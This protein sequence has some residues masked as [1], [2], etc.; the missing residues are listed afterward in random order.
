[1]NFLRNPAWIGSLTS[2]V[3]EGPG[4]W[5]LFNTFDISNGGANGST[6]STGNAN[7]AATTDYALQPRVWVDAAGRSGKSIRFPRNSE[8]AGGNHSHYRAYL[9]ADNTYLGL[10]NMQ[11]EGRVTSSILIPPQANYRGNV[12]TDP[13]VWWFGGVVASTGR[14][15]YFGFEL[16]ATTLGLYNEAGNTFNVAATTTLALGVQPTGWLDVDFRY[17]LH[18]STGYLWLKLGSYTPLYLQGLNTST[19]NPKTLYAMGCGSLNGAIEDLTY[20]GSVTNVRYWS[21]I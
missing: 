5:A 6:Y 12:F 16:A 2:T 7:V 1:M 17:R 18:A 9:Q 15:C 20:F 19:A 3:T 14:S 11:T 4:N 10:G 21:P 13:Q 8:V